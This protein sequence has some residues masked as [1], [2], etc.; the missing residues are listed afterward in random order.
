MIF[1]WTEIPLSPTHCKLRKQDANECENRPEDQW[2]NVLWTGERIFSLNFCDGR[3]R[4]RRLRGQCFAD[5]VI[6]QAIDSEV[7]R[8]WW[9]AFV[10]LNEC[11]QI[12]WSVIAARCWDNILLSII[13]PTVHQHGFPYRRTAQDH[14]LG[15]GSWLQCVNRISESS[16]G[17]VTDSSSIEHLCNEFGRGI[18]QSEA[19]MFFLVHRLQDKSTANPQE[20]QRNDFRSVTDD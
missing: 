3:V 1:S 19:Q 20:P 9:L 15:E 7:A 8:L 14:M 11:V 6:L 13:V 2:K 12:Q 5:C 10:A 16:L 4:V 18:S 17:Q